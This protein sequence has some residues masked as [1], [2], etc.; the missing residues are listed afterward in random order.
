VKQ[1]GFVVGALAPS[2]QY[3]RTAY[4]V[5][6]DVEEVTALF[7]LLARYVVNTDPVSIVEEL[8]PVAVPVYGDQPLAVGGQQV[9]RLLE[10]QPSAQTRTEGEVRETLAD[11]LALKGLES[12]LKE[13]VEVR[14][15]ELIAGRHSMRQSFDRAQ[16]GQMGPGK[17]APAVEWL[18]GID[19]LSPGSFDLLTTTILFPV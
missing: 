7:H 10:A 9:A 6:P 11:A 4:V 8:L 2:P 1:Q 19:D 3:G 18:K 13:A 16:D 14:R 17:G 15:R 12:L 5:T